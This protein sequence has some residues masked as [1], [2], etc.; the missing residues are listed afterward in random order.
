MEMDLPLL[1]LLQL[2]LQ[3]SILPLHPY[4]IEIAQPELFGAAAH[5]LQPL[6]TGGGHGN[7]QPL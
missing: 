5:V 4:Q 6:Q 3:F 7:D 1:I 2:P